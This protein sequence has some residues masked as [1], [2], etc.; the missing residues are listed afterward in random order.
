MTDTGEPLEERPL[1]NTAKSMIPMEHIQE[2]VDNRKCRNHVYGCKFQTKIFYCT[3]CMM[4][5]AIGTDFFYYYD[6][7]RAED[8]NY[9]YQMTDWQRDNFERDYDYNTKWLNNYPRGATMNT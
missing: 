7:L 1:F 6:R 8:S 4:H 5:L 2:I 9:A 3:C